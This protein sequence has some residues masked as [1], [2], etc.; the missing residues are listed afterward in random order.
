MAAYTRWRRS[1]AA[2][3]SR[4][5]GQ[6]LGLRGDLLGIDV[7]RL[8]PGAGVGLVVAG[9]FEGD[10]LGLHL[11]LEP[12][13]GARLLGDR[14]ERL[15]GAVLLLDLERGGV[16]QRRQGLAR[17]LADEAVELGVQLLDLLDVGLLAG[18]QVLGGRHVVQAERLELLLLVR[19]EHEELFLEVRSTAQSAVD[20]DVAELGLHLR[21]A[22]EPEGDDG[23]DQPDAGDDQADDHRGRPEIEHVQR[24]AGVGRGRR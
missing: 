24:L 8:D 3:C 9:A 15:E 20:L 16:A 18:E 4:Q 10:L 5:L 1:S 6:A 14:P 12:L 17:L 11:D 2:S 13:P 22:P 7:V 21:A 23:Q 19:L